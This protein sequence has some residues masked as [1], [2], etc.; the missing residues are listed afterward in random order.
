MSLFL[1][2]SS[3]IYIGRKLKLVFLFN[4]FVF[5]SCLAQNEVD[6]KS[7]D[8]KDT[9]LVQKLN[10]LATKHKY[11]NA[12]SLF[13]LSQ[14]ALKIS[15]EIDYTRGKNRALLLIASYYADNGKV[16]K[17]IDTYK[18]ILNSEYLSDSEIILTKNSF[19][20]TYYY[21][22]N[23]AKSLSLYLEALEIATKNKDIKML[24]MLNENIAN[25]YTAQ[26]D[27]HQAII[28]LEKAVKLNDSIGDQFR[29]A[30]TL[31]NFANVYA[32]EGKYERAMFNINK[33]VAVFEKLHNKKWIAQ[34]YKTKGNIYLQQ[35]KYDWAL[36]W[37]DQSALMHSKIENLRG[38]TE[39]LNGMTV[40]YI[41]LEKDSLALPLAQEAFEIS[42][43]INA[44]ENLGDAAKNLYILNKKNN[45]YSE[46]LNYHELYQNISHS[47][48][49]AE[50]NQSLALQKTKMEHEKQKE[51][52]VAENSIE[53]ARQRR[54]LYFSFAVLLILGGIIFMT[55]RSKKAHK[56]LND[57]LQAKQE[58]LENRESELEEINLTKDKL[59]SII[60]HDL[61][62]PIGALLEVLKMIR[63]GDIKKSEFN[64]FVP[65]LIK[66]VDHISFT[67]NNLLS[68]GKSQ[69]DGSTTNPTL[70]GLELLIENNIKLLSET[71]KSKFIT[72]KNNISQDMH[73]FSDANQL[74]IVVRNIISN[75]LKF[76][77]ERGLI[78]I[79][80]QEKNKVWILS[81]SDTGVG[82]DKD[83]LSKIFSKS[84]NITTFGT[85]NEKG[86]GLGLNLCKEMVEKNGGSIWVES[87]VNKGS[88]FY[89]SVPKGE[90]KYKNVS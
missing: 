82:M 20:L 28:F 71:A 27:Y 4:C 50:N 51:F 64:Q 63:S 52:I 23:Y 48:S 16:Q 10:K 41:G 89:F 54:L 46:A 77:P 5:M 25:L 14:R 86:T 1:T 21:A 80:A 34:A 78:T 83:T 3:S 53:L 88:C 61:R 9:L 31:C 90:K 11:Y 56:S 79:D 12:D 17:A 33:S 74:D 73:S 84:E 57:K 42:E 29:S 18:G 67:L 24:S 47:I 37:F 60:G 44:M 65:R 6:K 13:V 55:V 45:N 26:K 35:K 22:G 7:Y 19:G 70:Y 59:F 76:T 81:I 38:K 69:L 49:R 66:D 43:N 68:W 62:G 39:L 40:A 15:E 36:R 8:K 58:V 85:N 2:Y 72:I 87:E 30:K 75:A 32:K